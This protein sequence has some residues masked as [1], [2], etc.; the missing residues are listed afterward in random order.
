M[1]VGGYR[2]N[3]LAWFSMQLSL[4]DASHINLFINSTMCAL[5]V[6]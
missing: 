5:L 4:A 2:T 3:K 1:G 6:D